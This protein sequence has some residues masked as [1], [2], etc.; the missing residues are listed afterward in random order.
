MNAVGLGGAAGSGDAIAELIKQRLLQ[1]Q[2]DEVGRHNLVNEDLG[3]RTLAS[4]DADRNADNEELKRQHDL[5]DRNQR[6]QRTITR[7]N[8]R[9]VDDATPG[10][11]RSMVTPAEKTAETELGAPESLYG[12]WQPEFTGGQEF[13]K[14]GQTGPSPEGM[15]YLGTQTQRDAGRKIDNTAASTAERERQSQNTDMTKLLIA[16]LT[17]ATREQTA[18][19]SANKPGGIKVMSIRGPNGENIT[20]AVNAN[21]EVV[22]AGPSQLPGGMKQGEANANTLVDQ[23]DAISKQGEDNGWK[24]VGMMTAPAQGFWKKATGKGSDTNDMLRTGLDSLAA[25]IAHEKYGSAFTATERAQ[26]SKFAPTSAM[27]APA[28]KNRLAILK[29][30]VGQRLAELA[31]GKPLS[32]ATPLQ[33]AQGAPGGTDGAPAAAGAGGGGG[34]VDWTRDANGRLVPPSPGPK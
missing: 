10:G 13:E 33:L 4:R 6:E 19:I 18:R 12:G 30:Q 11:T 23:I 22:Y 21:G 3:R 5:I 32:A 17:N 9:P 25:E 1:Q 14:G 26:M 2:A 28:I 8:L 20:A 31:G 24:G 29:R 16:Q 15:P 7:L 34:V 27:S